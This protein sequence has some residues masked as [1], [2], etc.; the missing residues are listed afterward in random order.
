M[1]KI[2][3]IIK[4]LK[5]KCDGRGEKM[6][7]FI[8]SMLKNYSEVLGFTELEIIESLEKKRTYWCLNYYQEANMPKLEKDIVI[9]NTLDEFRKK[10]PSHKFRCPICGGVSTDP[11]TCDSGKE[12]EKGKICDWKSYGLFGT[13]G[14]GY[15]FIIKDDFLEYAV[16]Y[17]IFRPIELEG[18]ENEKEMDAVLSL[19]RRKM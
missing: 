5:T 8:R 1:D 3:E 11:Q 15:G 6:E 17:D 2:D 13:M 9:F 16:I 18:I 14:K 7:A 12:M 19:E 4:E 10:F